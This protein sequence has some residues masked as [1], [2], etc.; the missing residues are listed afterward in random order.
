MCL[1]VVH[2]LQPGRPNILKH[3]KDEILLHANCAQCVNYCM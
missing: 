1:H 3:I 2:A